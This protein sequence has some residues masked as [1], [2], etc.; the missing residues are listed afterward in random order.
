MKTDIAALKVELADQADVIREIHGQT[1]HVVNPNRVYGFGPYTR[2][3][4]STVSFTTGVPVSRVMLLKNGRDLTKDEGKAL[5]KAKRR[6][7]LLCTIRAAHRGRVH[8]ATFLQSPELLDELAREW[9]TFE[10]FDVVPAEE[11]APA[12]AKAEVVDAS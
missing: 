8:S 4:G 2:K 11:E 6:V 1:R 10:K 9:R 3:D 7:T 5:H 12:E